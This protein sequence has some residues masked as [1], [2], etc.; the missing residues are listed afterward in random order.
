MPVAVEEEQTKCV[1][2][3]LPCVIERTGEANVSKYFKPEGNKVIFEENS[4]YPNVDS[5]ASFRGRRLV[6]STI[7]IPD[8]YSRND[9]SLTP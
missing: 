9:A 7:S 3:R 2:H 5:T 4:N 1:V 6:S 8:N